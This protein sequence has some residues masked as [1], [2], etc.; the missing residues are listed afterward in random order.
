M[1]RFFLTELT[2][3]GKNAMP[4]AVQKVD[5]ASLQHGILVAKRN[6]TPV[7]RKQGIAHPFPHGAT[8]RCGIPPGKPWRSRGEA[9]SFLIR[10]NHWPPG[11]GGNLSFLCFLGFGA[12]SDL[13]GRNTTTASLSG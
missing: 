10:P 13:R 7:Q 9:M 1:I 3:V 8:G 12:K 4:A 5:R 2:A 11:N 6:Q